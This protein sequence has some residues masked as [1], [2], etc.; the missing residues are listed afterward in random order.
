MDC[1]SHRL[2]CPWDST[3]KNAMPSSGGSSQPRDWTQVS[4]IAGELFTIWATRKAQEYWGG[5]PIHSPGDPPKPGI[6]P[7][8][9]ALASGFLITGPPGKSPLHVCFFFFNKVIKIQHKHKITQIIFKRIWKP[10]DSL[11]KRGISQTNQKAATRGGS[12]NGSGHPE[13]S[14]K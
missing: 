3:G 13:L 11:K 2:T 10:G 12:S 8:S 4:R 9:P 1:S 6:E 7:G 5:W 14:Q